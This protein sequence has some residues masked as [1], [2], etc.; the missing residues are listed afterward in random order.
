MSTVSLNFTDCF[1]TL[2]I[3]DSFIFLLLA[4]LN[5]VI[6]HCNCSKGTQF[7]APSLYPH[8][9]IS[10]FHTFLSEISSLI[11][12]QI[13]STD[14]NSSKQLPASRSYPTDS[15]WPHFCTVD[16]DNDFEALVKMSSNRWK[17]THWG[18][19]MSHSRQL[20]LALKKVLWNGRGPKPQAAWYICASVSLPRQ[21][22]LGL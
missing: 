1:S 22:L 12:W 17:L 3:T 5:C 19:K 15:K 16:N 9:T 10:F 13:I 6:P 4:Q 20:Y 11:D 14:Q 8:S 7:V 21:N 18:Y 2:W